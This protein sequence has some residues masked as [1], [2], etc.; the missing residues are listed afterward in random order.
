MSDTGHYLEV[1]YF[2]GHKGNI[3]IFVN[4]YCLHAAG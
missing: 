2:F 1:V 3:H 4:E